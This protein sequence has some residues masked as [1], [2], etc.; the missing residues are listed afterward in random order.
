MD[1]SEDGARV[2]YLQAQVRLPRVVAIHSGPAHTACIDGALRHQ[3][4]TLYYVL[5]GQGTFTRRRGHFHVRHGDLILVP[6]DEPHSVQG[7]GGADLRVV[8]FHEDAVDGALIG[9]T[10]PNAVPLV[11]GLWG[12]ARKVGARRIQSD[13]L[14]SWEARFTLL[15]DAE[16]QPSPERMLTVPSVMALLT[17]DMLRLEPGHAQRPL[18]VWRN[19]LIAAMFLYIEKHYRFPIGVQNVAAAVG[20]AATYLT[21]LVHRET[22]RPILDWLVARRMIE[23]RRLL[24][25]AP[26]SLA[27]IAEMAG[28]PDANNFTRKFAE[29]HGVTPGRWRAIATGAAEETAGETLVPAADTFE[30]LWAAR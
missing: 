15:R 13:D 30:A 19:P 11:F 12:W 6:P 23:A 5:R 28:Y 21:T 26:E 14:L 18:D 4:F 2:V 3:F 1:A 29:L 17:I 8:G 24:G 22:G 16:H 27:T 7:L 20:R 9:E 10:M 25:G